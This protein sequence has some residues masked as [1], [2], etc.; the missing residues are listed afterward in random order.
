MKR[1][2]FNFYSKLYFRVLDF[3]CQHRLFG[4]DSLLE[5]VSNMVE[6]LKYKKTTKEAVEEIDY[7]IKIFGEIRKELLGQTGKKYL[8]L[9]RKDFHETG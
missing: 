1:K 7:A 6:C 9:L 8:L 5:P 3:F 4:F 2:F